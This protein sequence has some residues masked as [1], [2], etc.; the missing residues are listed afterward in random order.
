MQHSSLKRP[1]SPSWRTRC[2]VTLHRSYQL[3]KALECVPL[4]LDIS[5]LHFLF[6]N[7]L[8]EDIYFGDYRAVKVL[9]DS[10]LRD[11]KVF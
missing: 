9:K 7:F 10:I 6:W 1:F 2:F 3:E 8:T 4:S 11:L 5:P